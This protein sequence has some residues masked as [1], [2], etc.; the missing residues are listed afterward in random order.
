[1]NGGPALLKSIQ[2]EKKKPKVKKARNEKKKRTERPDVATKTIGKGTCKQ[3]RV[4]GD[5]ER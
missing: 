1:M 5:H 2:P 3:A 4:S